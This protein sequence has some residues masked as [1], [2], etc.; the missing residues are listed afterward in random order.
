MQKFFHSQAR[1]LQ[2]ELEMLA[3]RL[4]IAG[5]AIFRFLLANRSYELYATE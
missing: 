4:G 5:S 1:A 2:A 3:G